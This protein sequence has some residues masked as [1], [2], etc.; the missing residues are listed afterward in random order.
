M[1]LG[2]ALP[3]DDMIGYYQTLQDRIVDLPPT[4]LV[5]ASENLDFSE[6]LQ[7]D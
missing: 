3:D 6:M 7:K 5:L 4:V 1:F 2:L